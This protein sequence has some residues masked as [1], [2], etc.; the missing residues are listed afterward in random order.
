MEVTIERSYDGWKA[1]GGG[2]T[3]EGEGRKREAL[4]RRECGELV[5]LGII[6]RHG[7]GCFETQNIYSAFSR[8]VVLVNLF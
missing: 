3:E 4:L 1:G 7:H 6:S 2:W 8:F 5:G